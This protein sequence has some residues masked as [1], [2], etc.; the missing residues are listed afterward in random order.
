MLKSIYNENYFENVKDLKRLILTSKL[1]IIF[2]RHQNKNVKDIK[3][4]LQ[5]LLTENDINEIV[6]KL[7]KMQSK[8]SSSN[9][10]LV[11]KAL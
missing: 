8:V 9:R 4:F 3:K 1:N 10:V 5:V 2:S 6:D 7:K 11:E